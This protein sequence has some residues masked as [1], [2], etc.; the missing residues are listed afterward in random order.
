[1]KH[2]ATTTTPPFG[3]VLK[4]WRELRRVSQLQLSATADVSQR[5]L[6]FLETGRAA[7]SREMVTHLATI[8][9]VP[10]RDRNTWLA[11]AGYA[12]I[13]PETNLN[14]PAMEQVRSVLEQI[15]TAHQPFPAYVVDRCW[16]VILTNQSATTLTARLVNPAAASNFGGNVLRLSLHPDGLRHHLLN[17][18]QA[19]TTLLDRLER[20]VAQRPNDRTLGAL[21]TEVRDYPGIA[22]LP[23]RTTFPGGQDL[24]I[25]LHIHTPHLELR[26]FT[27]IATIGA[28]HDITLEELRLETLLPADPE[29]ETALR[30]LAADTSTG[31]ER[32]PRG[33]SSV[34]SPTRPITP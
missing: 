1:M 8:L 5:H 21:L 3:H 33:M 19:A 14:E 18:E 34:Q 20:E 15:L 10:L 12:S 2:I 22:D 6:S 31:R 16:D 13:Y 17:W 23:T 27:T 4:E 7:P 30:R 28:A 24:A 11:A 25:P 29:T 32:V 26:L 9:E